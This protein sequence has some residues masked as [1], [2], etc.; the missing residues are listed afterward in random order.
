MI[1]V[2][3][4]LS[5]AP[6]K[7]LLDANVLYPAPLRDLLMSLAARELYQPLWTE[8][9]HSEW[10]RNVLKDLPHVTRERLERTKALMLQ[11]MPKATVEGYEHLTDTLDLPDADDRHVGNAV[12]LG[13]QDFQLSRVDVEPARDDQIL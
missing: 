5:D 13:K 3:Q 10:M 12:N 2:D 6:Q 7:A 8:T 4:S 9:I 1:G 11:H